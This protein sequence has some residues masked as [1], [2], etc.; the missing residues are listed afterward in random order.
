[1]DVGNPSNL[2]RINHLF[3]QDITEIRKETVTAFFDDK[4]T[5]LCI[6]NFYQKYNYIIDPHGAIG[7]LAEGEIL[8]NNESN[9]NSIILETASASKFKDTIDEILDMDINLPERL[10]IIINKP[11]QSI[12]LNSGFEDFK[13]YLQNKT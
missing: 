8:K 7:I 2:E 5:K 12:K 10:K 11:K 1:M 4:E 13:N 9:I 3:N 6:K